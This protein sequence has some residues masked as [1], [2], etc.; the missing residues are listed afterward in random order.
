MDSVVKSQYIEVFDVL[1]DMMLF[2]EYPVKKRIPAIPNHLRST[3]L[4]ICGVTFSTSH[5]V[6]LCHMTTRTHDTYY[7]SINDTWVKY[8]RQCTFHNLDLRD[9]FRFLNPED[10]V[11]KKKINNQLYQCG[12]RIHCMEHG[13]ICLVERGDNEVSSL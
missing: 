12:G 8:K 2:N 10:K 6:V 7:L 13:K 11:I 4:E 1:Q 9:N 3:C 5:F